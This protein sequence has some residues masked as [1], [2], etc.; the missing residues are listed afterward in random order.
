MFR[1]SLRRLN[2]GYWDGNL[3]SLVA[4]GMEQY[5]SQNH[6][7]FKDYLDHVKRVSQKVKQESVKPFESEGLPVIFLRDPSADKEGIARGI[8]EKRG[9]ESG[10][11]C[12]LSAVEPSPSFEHRGIHIVRRIRPCQVLYQYQIHPEAGWM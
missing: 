3:Q 10:L 6:I 11:V 12:A 8:A 2:Y 7:L 4:Q 9:V 5:L 1:G